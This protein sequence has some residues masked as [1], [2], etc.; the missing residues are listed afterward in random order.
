M[1]HINV[2]SVQ[3]SPFNL[4]GGEENSGI[5]LFNDDLI[6]SELATDHLIKVQDTPRDYPF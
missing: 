2:I 6:V 3:D 1:T 4:F 5:G